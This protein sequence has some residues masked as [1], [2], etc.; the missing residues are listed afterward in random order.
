MKRWLG[1]VLCVCAMIPSVAVAGGEGK[2]D[3]LHKG[4]TLYAFTDLSWLKGQS[5]GT[6]NL[7]SDI[8]TCDNTGCR[9]VVHACDPLYV[10]SQIK[11]QTWV[12]PADERLRKIMD[13][14]T[15]LNSMTSSPA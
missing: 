3:K 1:A 14:S 4:D 11:D 15:F 6:K 8:L 12:L 7:P 13:P 9:Y 2:K 5:F 10:A